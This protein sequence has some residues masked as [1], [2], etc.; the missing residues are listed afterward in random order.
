MAVKTY[1]YYE[2]KQITPHFNSNE[3]RCKC[4][5]RHSIKIDSDLC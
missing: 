5:K 3:F 2:G 1:G 4:G